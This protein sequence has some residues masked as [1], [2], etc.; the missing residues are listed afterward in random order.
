MSLADFRIETERLVLRLPQAG[1]FERYAELQA[2]EEAARWIGGHQP[3]AAAWRKFLQQPGAWMIQGFGMFSVTDRATGRWLG[4]L[5]P[6]RPE[7]WPGNEIG[8]SFHPDAWGRGYATEAAVAAI[9]W[10]LEHLDWDNFIHCIAPANTASQAVAKRL[11]ST[12]RGPGRLPPPHEDAEVE[13]WGQTRNQW[14]VNRTR[15]P[16]SC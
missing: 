14:R 15:F 6:W 1:D 13:I 12:L 8:Y 5:G 3:R 9:D 7:G 4:Q 11:G 2:D 10:A 16:A